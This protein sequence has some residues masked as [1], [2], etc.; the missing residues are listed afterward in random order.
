MR[1]ARVSSYDYQKSAGH[2]DCY[3]EFKQKK[4]Y[5]YDDKKKSSGHDK[6]KSY[7]HGKKSYGYDMKSYGYDKKL[8]GHDK[9][10]SCG[11][12]KSKSYGKRHYY[13]S[14]L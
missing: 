1:K 6:H 5:G 7:S 13:G 4:S 12:D 8:H 9:G 2:Y 14:W 11:C 10:K 3:C